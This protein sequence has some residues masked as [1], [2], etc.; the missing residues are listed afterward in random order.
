MAV[1][2]SP[3]C[4]AIAALFLLHTVLAVDDP[5]DLVMNE[6]QYCI[7]Y[8]GYV[9]ADI[10]LPK[11]S[12]PTY[13]YN[14]TSL[15]P[16]SFWTGY[17]SGATLEICPPTLNYGEENALALTA[18]LAFR[19]SGGELN[20]PIDN[21][22]LSP[23]VTNGSVPASF[24]NVPDANPGLLTKDLIKSEPY[25][26]VWVINGTQAS[27]T[28]YPDA[29]DDSH[30]M[31]ISCS[32]PGAN[33]YCG[34]YEDTHDALTGGCWRAQSIAFNM[35]TPLN[36]TFRFARNEASVDIFTSSEYVT[37]LGNRTGGETH[38]YLQFSGTKQ[39]PSVTAYDYWENS[40]VSYEVEA[41]YVA[42]R[43]GMTIEDDGEGMPLL[44]NQ[45]GG[46]EWYDSKNGTFSVQSINGGK[47][48]DAGGR[49]RVHWLGVVL[50]IVMVFVLA[51]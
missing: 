35:H 15:C 9:Q 28:E 46:G 33:I 27:L 3:L 1:I 6:Y 47:G 41:M 18:T 48:N 36:Y 10:D 4:A 25:A 38:V 17:V 14:G 7:K 13:N 42:E 2:R 44:V 16:T 21:L 8:F 29:S 23:S 20:G 22:S 31:Y 34:G 24:F 5:N 51:G 40:D 32:Y 12:I 50:G 45:T 49:M 11:D 26:P 30:G 19:T 39:L 37:Y 43:K